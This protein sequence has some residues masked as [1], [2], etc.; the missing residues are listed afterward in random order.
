MLPE[1]SRETCSGRQGAEVRVCG[2]WR[3][4]AGD[5][6]G[7]WYGNGAHHLAPFLRQFFLGVPCA[8]SEKRGDTLIHLLLALP[9]VTIGAI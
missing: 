7:K 6:G 4:E 1:V 9:C 2:A 5:G 3:G 8:V